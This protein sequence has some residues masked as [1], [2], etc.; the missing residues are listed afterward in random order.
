MASQA[1]T[2]HLQQLLANTY[3]LY[4]KTQNYH[5]HVKG[6]HFSQLHA[7][8][9]G[10]YK[11]LAEMIDELAERIVILGGK[12]I[13][14]FKSLSQSN[15]ISDG[16]SSLTWHGM[17]SDLC[18]DHDKILSNLKDVLSVA[19]QEGDEGTIALISEKIGYFEKQHWFL[20]NHLSS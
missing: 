7:L 11:E 16:D 5:W 15:T 4:L 14:T 13:A 12:A 9:E 10:Q 18:G 17:L 6:P 8:F 1:V 19:H 2:K 20:K 3:G